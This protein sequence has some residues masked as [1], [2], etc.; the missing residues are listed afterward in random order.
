[1]L[2]VLQENI[3]HP[4]IHSWALKMLV[5]NQIFLMD[6]CATDIGSRSQKLHWKPIE[7][8]LE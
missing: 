7:A 6:G 3:L 2:S 1:M 4:C 5:Y 8:C